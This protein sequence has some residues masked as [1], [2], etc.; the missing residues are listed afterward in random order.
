[1]RSSWAPWLAVVAF[2]L[3]PSAGSGAPAHGG[4][5]LGSSVTVYGANW[6]GACKSLEAKLAQKNIPFDVIDVDRQPDA[7]ARARQAAGGPNGI[8]L[9]GVRAGGEQTWVVGDNADRIERAY[10]G[11]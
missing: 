2:S 9:T 10:R 3:F 8:P 1:M 7:Y 5:Q 4:W 11:N 6:C